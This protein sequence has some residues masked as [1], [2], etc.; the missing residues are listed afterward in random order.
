MSNPAFSDFGVLAQSGSIGALVTTA[1]FTP[2]DVVRHSA[3]ASV[4]SRKAAPSLPETFRA[5]VAAGGGYRTLWRGLLPVSIA[6]GLSPPTCLLF[7]EM[8]SSEATDRAAIA[9]GIS[10]FLLQPFE[11]LRTCQ[12]AQYHLPGRAK[13]SEPLPTEAVRMEH[14][15]RRPFEII[16]SEG[17]TSFWRGLAPTLLRDVG[18]TAAYLA[19]YMRLD[20]LCRPEALEYAWEAPPPPPLQAAVMSS[21]SAVAAAAVT[22]PF[23]VVKVQIQ[24]QNIVQHH[25]GYVKYIK[26]H[27]I[28]TMKDIYRLAGWS[29]FTAGLAARCSRAALVGFALGPLFEYGLVVSRDSLRPQRFILHTQDVDAT[30]VHPRA[31]D[32]HGGMRRDR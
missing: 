6:A 15:A 3:Q 26:P 32:L 10:T 31:S 27:M 16:W 19:L 2:L 25:A 23:D 24:T 18:S 4:L 1:L 14:L 29:G 30:I 17:V 21:I 9:R 11:F 28:S 8:Q 13:A 22:H 7:Y 5:V 20:S 12:Q